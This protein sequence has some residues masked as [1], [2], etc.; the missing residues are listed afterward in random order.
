MLSYRGSD[1]SSVGPFPPLAFP[2][3]FIYGIIE[4]EAIS[5]MVEAVHS[6]ACD[7]NHDF[8]RFSE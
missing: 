8:V 1:R 7:G 2:S 5:S 3:E 4:I 6:K